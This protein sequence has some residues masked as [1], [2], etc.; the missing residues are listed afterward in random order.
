[1]TTT[2][3][4]WPTCSVGWVVP[5]VACVTTEEPA[6]GLP[7][8]VAHLQQ[9][10]AGQGPLQLQQPQ[11]VGL[12][13]AVAALLVLASSPVHQPQQRP[14]HRHALLH[15]AA[16]AAGWWRLACKPWL[17]LL[18]LCW[19]RF[20]PWQHLL[21]LGH[22]CCY[23]VSRQQI[24]LGM[25]QQHCCLLQEG[26]ICMQAAV[27]QQAAQCQQGVLVPRVDGQS[28]AQ[29]LLSAIQAASTH[30][31]GCKLVPGLQEQQ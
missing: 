28:L 20:C 5:K 3:Q 8:R 4:V 10:L 31:E 22:G 21:L 14:H 13:A 11:A 17:P 9:W 27:P 7:C 12:K 6:L 18:L 2:A 19:L 16:R 24:I 23:R 30:A 26:C 15:A 1:M 25:Q 29:A